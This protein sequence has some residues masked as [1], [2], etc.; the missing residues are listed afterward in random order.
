MIMEADLGIIDE[1]FDGIL[2]KIQSANCTGQLGSGYLCG[3]LAYPG[4]HVSMFSRI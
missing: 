4:D 2:V 3:L 1:I